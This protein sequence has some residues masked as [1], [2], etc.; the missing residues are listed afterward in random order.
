M[1]IETV[2]ITGANRGIGL[3]T[4]ELLGQHGYHV[5][6][7]SRK[8]DPEQVDVSDGAN[9]TGELADRGLSVDFQYLDVTSQ[10]EIQAVSGYVEDTYG[11][12]D[13]LINNAGIKADESPDGESR[14]TIV[15][16]RIQPIRNSME[17]NVYGP[18]MVTQAFIPLLLKS[19]NPRIVN[20]SSYMGKLSSMTRA[21]PGY[22]ISKTA[23]NAVT[24]IFA[25]ELRDHGIKVNSVHPGWIRTRMG[26]PDA[27]YDSTYG[28]E[29]VT[30]LVFI[31][32]N[33][34]TGG[35]FEQGKA[36]DW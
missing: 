33:G 8:P 25:S 27:T 6:L 10:D 21:W 4:A 11:R 18:I 9:V 2:L 15:K 3:A 28:A 31:D 26:G 22:R 24:R 29:S 23:L 32:R 7:T 17:V 30:K 16:T 5:I 12:L 14:P 1:D 13:V 36:I 20:V 34:P 19:D 35:F